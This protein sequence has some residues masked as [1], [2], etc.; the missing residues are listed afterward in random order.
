MESN[1]EDVAQALRN[2]EFLAELGDV[3]PE[4]ELACKKSLKDFSSVDNRW[5]ADGLGIVI[6]YPD[7]IRV[8]GPDF[9]KF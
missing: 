1:S 8:C 3:Q 9:L 6:H 7:Y 5:F 2:P 4:Y